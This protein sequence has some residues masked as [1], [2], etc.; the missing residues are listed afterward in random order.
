MTTDSDIILIDRL[1]DL[2]PAAVRNHLSGGEELLPL[3][4]GVLLP[5]LGAPLLEVPAALGAM[6][7]V[8]FRAAAAADAPLCVGLDAEAGPAEPGPRGLHA[9]VDRALA[10]ARE[11]AFRLPFVLHARLGMVDPEDEASVDAAR[12]K[13]LEAVDAGVTSVQLGAFGEPESAARLLTD[14]LG[15]ASDNG[16]CLLYTS[17][18]PR[19]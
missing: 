9:A 12:I 6:L 4:P 14:V 5:H 19:D 1:L 16:L 10:A 13:V 17:P 7:E 15:P 18:S 11:T 3:S 2:R 8:A